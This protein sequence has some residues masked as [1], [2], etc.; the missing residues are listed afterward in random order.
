MERIVTQLLEEIIARRNTKGYTYL[1][2]AIAIAADDMEKLKYLN[3]QIY[4]LIARNHSITTNG[5]QRAIC[6]TI[7]HTWENGDLEVLQR[8]FGDAVLDPLWKPANH[9][10]IS[11]IAEKARSIQK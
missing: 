5:V 2:E 7:A 8:Y 3:R 11:L 10:F 6:S 4:G 1:K 9:E